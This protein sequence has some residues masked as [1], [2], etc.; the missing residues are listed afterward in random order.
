MPRD[1]A[2]YKMGLIYVTKDLIDYIKVKHQIYF[3]PKKESW[4]TRREK[5]ARS[6]PKYGRKN[7]PGL[8]TPNE[9]DIQDKYREYVRLFTSVMESTTPEYRKSDLNC[10]YE[11][12]R[13]LK[14]YGVKFQLHDL[15]DKLRKI[16]GVE[17]NLY[18]SE[19]ANVEEHFVGKYLMQDNTVLINTSKT[20]SPSIIFHELLHVA[21]TH[22]YT[23]E[24]GKEQ[25]RSGL[26]WMVNGR[27]SFGRGILDGM[28]CY[29]AH[30]KFKDYG[31]KEKR[32]INTCIA[33]LL[34]QIVGEDRVESMYL[35]GDFMSFVDELKNYCPTDGRGLSSLNEVALFIKKI[36][37]IPQSE[38]LQ[39]KSITI[40]NLFY[41]PIK[42]FIT[43]QLYQ[44]K[45]IDAIPY[46]VIKE[47]LDK[48]P[49]ELR[50]DS[51]VV[52]IDKEKLINDV[53]DELNSYYPGIGY[54]T[55][56]SENEGYQRTA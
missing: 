11:N 32:D 8:G 5:Y 26:C 19:T 47:F 38:L 56:I 48:I 21:S 18:D 1:I 41:M 7:W 36:D 46:P 28:T 40:I 53:F 22:K 33:G 4:E 54:Q 14:V 30:K 20:G 13:T 31:Y 2:D 25:I 50:K 27:V 3:K 49:N 52:K 9:P 16:T 39:E 12:L 23:D 34:A 51:R 35:N 42:L 15:L 24:N 6:L 44:Y 37:S 10:F 45:R 17:Y 29:L 43:K 55:I